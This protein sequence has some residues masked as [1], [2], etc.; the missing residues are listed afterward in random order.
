MT[1]F[2]LTFFNLTKIEDINLIG[3]RLVFIPDKMYNLIYLERL[4]LDYN[5]LESLPPSIG[6]L[7][8]LDYLSIS[9]NHLDSIPS[10]IGLLSKLN[11]LNLLNAGSTVFIP[12]SLCNLDRLDDLFINSF[13]YVP[14]CLSSRKLRFNK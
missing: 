4:E 13:G 9:N 12:N 11:Y 3:N 6:M 8:S 7:Q 10:E 5:R 14:A 1:T 2:P